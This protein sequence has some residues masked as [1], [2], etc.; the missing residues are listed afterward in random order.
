MP[1]V[2]ER[3]HT[4]AAINISA[5]HD[6]GGRPS[7][8]LAPAVLVGI[9]GTG[10]ECLRRAK[11][12]I[13]ERLGH[14]HNI[15]FLMIDADAESFASRPG[16]ATVDDNERCFIGGDLVQPLL[17]HRSDHRWLFEQI[18][19]DIPAEHIA[20][21]A[22]GRGC[23][24]LRTSGRIAVLSAWDQVQG[25]LRNAI[26]EVQEITTSM[27][28]AFMQQKSSGLQSG[29]GVRVYIVGSLA[30]GTGSGAFL[31]VS[32]LARELATHSGIL[33]GIF[34]LPAAF[35]HDLRGSAD[36]RSRTRANAYAALRDL[37]AVQDAPQRPIELKVRTDS[38]GS[39]LELPPGK[40]L[41]DLAY[42]VDAKNEQGQLLP[43]ATSIFELVARFLL[44][45]TGTEIGAHARSLENN[46]QT[47]HGLAADPKTGLARRFS[48]FSA[49]TLC[50]PVERLRTFCTSAS[51]RE[52]V[53]DH[54]MG[55]GLPVAA[56]DTAVTAFLQDP[57]HLLDD[58]SPRDQVLDR[59]LQELD[60][61][62]HLGAPLSSGDLGLPNGFGAKLQVREF[63]RLVRV[64]LQEHRD[65]TM[66][67]ASR[68]TQAN[69]AFYLGEGD[70]PMPICEWIDNFIASEMQRSGARAASECL[71]VLGSA[72]RTLRGEMVSENR[73]WADHQRKDQESA[74]NE[75]MQQLEQMSALRRMWGNQ[76]VRLKH[77]AVD[78]F[79]IIVEGDLRAHARTT[80]LGVFAAGEKHVQAKSAEVSRF[81]GMAETVAA[82][83][84]N[85]VHHIL[86]AS[87][88]DFHQYAIEMDAT[89]AGYE[90]QYFDE[91]KLSSEALRGKLDEAAGREGVE[92]PT[93]L[94]RM[95]RMG[96]DQLEET[97]APLLDAAYVSGLVGTNVVSFLTESKDSAA[98]STKLSLLFDLCSPFWYTLPAQ[99]NTQYDHILSVGCAPTSI[100]GAGNPIIPEQV[101]KWAKQYATSVRGGQKVPPV[102]IP[103]ST[104]YELELVRHT[105]GARAWYLRDAKEWKREYE[106]SLT[107]KTYPVHTHKMLADIPDIFPDDSARGRLMFALGMALGFI[108]RRGDHYYLNIEEIAEKR[109]RVLHAT[110]WPT[111]FG[112][113]DTFVKPEGMESFDFVAR[114]TKPNAL[115]KLG[116]G[117]PKAL[118]ALVSSPERISLLDRAVSDYL[119]DAG[120]KLAKQ[121]FK[122]YVAVLAEREG[123]QIQSERKLIEGYLRELE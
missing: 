40:A 65:R 82:R 26:R 50:F 71:F 100:D 2:T 5:Q 107:D 119:S 85:E 104:P 81:I 83:L 53:E 111:I 120:L 91:H 23:G 69:L 21:I 94:L 62:G 88:R 93:L 38:K 72:F 13:T 42:L 9:G 15:R 29:D 35:D 37:Q 8:A 96:A 4:Y 87:R 28:M 27:R 101:D 74:L 20:R 114:K 31:D 118:E 99:I 95:L 89:P 54:L 57:A 58:R 77:R 22:Q 115:L 46:L 52:L 19:A 105:H 61:E 6:G 76:D 34:V 44:H 70:G 16:M 73:Q 32:L 112:E 45:E 39:L 117:R 116:Q 12:Q 109:L 47:I 59:L 98:V 55:R 102:A 67:R 48:T 49:T 33:T 56:R 41:F 66:D 75:A 78:A 92:V 10:V 64:R 123:E 110:D 51:L 60:S 18:P 63:A 3:S 11:Q 24:Q 108:A 80:A 36:Q 86:A 103:T 121:Q 84:L 30:G 17:E 97:F 7:H 1:K 79:N 122:A 14:T 106:A 25:A 90:Q 43:D 113:G 68:T